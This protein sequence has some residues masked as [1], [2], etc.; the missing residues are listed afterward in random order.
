MGVWAI[1]GFRAGMI[2]ARHQ[3][4]C[5]QKLGRTKLTARLPG[6]LVGDSAYQKPV[7]SRRC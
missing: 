6:G 5:L 2:S 4:P 1:V 7:L 3:G